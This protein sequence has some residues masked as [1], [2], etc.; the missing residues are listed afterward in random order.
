MLSKSWQSLLLSLLSAGYSCRFICPLWKPHNHAGLPAA[1]VPPTPLPIAARY[2]ALD[3]TKQFKG[4]L[5]QSSSSRSDGSPLS[6]LAAAR[7]SP[8][9]S[10]FATTPRGFPKDAAAATA[11]AGEDH[12]PSRSDSAAEGGSSIVRPAFS[13]GEENGAVQVREVFFFLCVWH[14]LEGV[15]WVYTGFAL[16][17]Q[18]LVRLLW[19]C[20]GSLS[21]VVVAVSVT[22]SRESVGRGGMFFS[23]ARC[24]RHCIDRFVVVKS[25][26]TSFAMPELF[27]A[28]RCA[29]VALSAYGKTAASPQ[30]QA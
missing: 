6:P 8:T 28:G 14:T 15:L 18:T 26:D 19:V 5:S 21:S 9:N 27:V 16:A 30:L 12:S 24:L 1:R 10:A 25:I 2:R 4:L 13:V 22:H 17:W 23:V 7:K 20:R 3:H 29:D 11:K